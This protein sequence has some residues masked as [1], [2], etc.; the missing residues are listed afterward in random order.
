MWFKERRHLHNVK[1]QDEAVSVQVE[2][3]AC[4]PED[5]IKVICEGGCNKQQISMQ[6]KQSSVGRRCQSRTFITGEEKSVLGFKA[7]NDR[8]TFFLDDDAAGDFKV[9]ARLIYYSEYSKSTLPVVYKQ[10]KT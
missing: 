9:K 5:L 8:L 1:V 7:S 3:A 4:C 2:A 6:T 10:N